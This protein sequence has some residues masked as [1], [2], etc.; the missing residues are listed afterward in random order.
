MKTS[1]EALRLHAD[2]VGRA[3]D[4]DTATAMRWAAD[5]IESLRAALAEANVIAGNAVALLKLAHTALDEVERATHECEQTEIVLDSYAE[6]NQQLSDRAERAKADLAEA[7]RKYHQ[8]LTEMAQTHLKALVQRDAIIAKAARERASLRPSVAEI[9][10][11]EAIA[12]VA[13]AER[14]R[15][16]YK[17]ELVNAGAVNERL[18]RRIAEAG[19]AIA[20]A[21]EVIEIIAG[22]R[23][24]IDNLMSHAE[25]AIA[26]LERTTK[27]GPVDP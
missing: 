8:N 6:E 18:A 26:F 17:A 4:P 3:D 2:I 25:I 15:D 24:C 22:K 19:A 20:A 27:K 23:Q 9:E 12:R 14:E 10:R 16:Y 21:R 1:P 7:E 11:D 5:D 13:E